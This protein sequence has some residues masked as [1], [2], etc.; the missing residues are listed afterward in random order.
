MDLNE[1]LIQEKLSATVKDC[2]SL[3]ERRCSAIDVQETNWSD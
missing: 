2:E 1:S 3:H